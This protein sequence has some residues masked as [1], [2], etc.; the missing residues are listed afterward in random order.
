[1]EMT[2]I[3]FTHKI[4]ETIDNMERNIEVIKSVIASQ[5]TLCELVNKSEVAKDFETFVNGLKEDNAKKQEQIDVITFRVNTLKDLVSV[6]KAE[7]KVVH[8]TAITTLML[9]CF[10]L[11]LEKPENYIEKAPEAQ[12]SKEEQLAANAGAAQTDEK[13]DA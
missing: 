8:D 9:L 3:D 2:V 5:S 4:E 1:M 12:A 10:G 11:G 7:D 13:K 6:L